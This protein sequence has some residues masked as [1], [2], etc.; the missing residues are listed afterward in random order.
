[1]QNFR[2]LVLRPQT[3]AYRPQTAIGFRPRPPPPDR[4]WPP[5]AGGFTPRPPTQPSHSEFLSTRL[6]MGEVAKT[7]NVI[8]HQNQKYEFIMQLNKKKAL[9]N[10]YIL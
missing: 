9:I 2:A 10:N 1:M 5:A 7:P 6:Q 4:H 8:S 3:L